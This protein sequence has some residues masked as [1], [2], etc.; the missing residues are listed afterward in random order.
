MVICSFEESFGAEREGLKWQRRETYS[1]DMSN[2]SNISGM[3]QLRLITGR[4][5]IAS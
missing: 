3:F 4:C 5:G 1:V 2:N